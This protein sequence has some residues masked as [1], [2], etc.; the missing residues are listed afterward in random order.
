MQQAGS[1]KRQTQ[2]RIQIQIQ[3]QIQEQPTDLICNM[4]LERRWQSESDYEE[5]CEYEEYA[6]YAEYAECAEYAEYAE[7]AK[8]AEYA[9][10]GFQFFCEW[11]VWEWF[12]IFKRIHE[13]WMPK[14]QK[15]VWVLKLFVRLRGGWLGL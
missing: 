4:F 13:F 14:T 10:Y 8:Y 11:L 7:Y 9:E 6:E 2:R 1:K 12:T 15:N 3:R 5:C